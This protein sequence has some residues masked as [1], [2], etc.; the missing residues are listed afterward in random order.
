MYSR[1]DCNKRIRCNMQAKDV[2]VVAL[3]PPSIMSRSLTSVA[4]VMKDF[5]TCISCFADDSKK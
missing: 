2:P 1:P 5:S 3:D 4:I